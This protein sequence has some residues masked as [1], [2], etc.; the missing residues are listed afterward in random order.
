MCERNTILVRGD[1]RRM[2]GIKAVTVGAKS[3]SARAISGRTGRE[4]RL[5]LRVVDDGDVESTKRAVLALPMTL[6]IVQSPSLEES[7]VFVVQQDVGVG[8]TLED[9]LRMKRS[10]PE[11]PGSQ[12]AQLTWNFR[13]VMLNTEGSP[14]GTILRHSCCQRFEIS[15]PE[16][17]ASGKLTSGR[18]TRSCARRAL[19]NGASTPHRLR[20]A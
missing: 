6:E 10:G 2:I 12:A 9:I 11:I 5:T 4:V 3:S 18:P 1:S 13:F 19:A 17:D 20:A 16:P 15:L 7:F 14:S 8:H